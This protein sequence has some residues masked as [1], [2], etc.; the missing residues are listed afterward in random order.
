[1]CKCHVTS[2]VYYNKCNFMLQRNAIN[3]LQDYC[4]MCNCLEVIHLVMPRLV[5]ARAAFCVDAGHM[6]F[7]LFVSKMHVE[8]VILSK[9]K[10][11]RAVVSIDD[12]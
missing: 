7:C 3:R 9:A 4:V 11:F 12:A 8:N 2:L 6:F 5:V 10:Q 1:M